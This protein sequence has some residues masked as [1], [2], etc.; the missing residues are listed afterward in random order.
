[1]LA[2]DSYSKIVEIN[3]NEKIFIIYFFIEPAFAGGL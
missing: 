1:M 3:S 2:P